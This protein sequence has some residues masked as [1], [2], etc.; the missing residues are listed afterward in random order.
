VTD[1]RAQRSP[2]PEGQGIAASRWRKAWDAYSRTVNKAALPIVEPAAAFRK[3][4]GK[5]PDEFSFPGVTI[6]LPTYLAARAAN[7]QA[8]ATP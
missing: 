6:D 3:H 1:F 5:H 2:S 8:A 7:Q 4:F